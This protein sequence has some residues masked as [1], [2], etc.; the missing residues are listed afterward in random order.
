MGIRCEDHV[1]PLYPQK[2][3]LTSPTG[4]GRSVGIVRSRTKATEIFF[5]LII[6]YDNVY[7]RIRLGWVGLSSEMLFCI[8]LC[9]VKLGWDG[10]VYDKVSLCLFEL[11]W[12]RL[13]WVVLDWIWL[14]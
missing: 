14:G 5:Y 1:T 8:A 7:V 2:L 3:E 11:V 4:G 9:W 13:S 10:L 6:V 12:V